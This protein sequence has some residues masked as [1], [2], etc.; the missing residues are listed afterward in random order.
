MSLQAWI[1]CRVVAPATPSA[2]QDASLQAP[3]RLTTLPVQGTLCFMFHD[4]LS[5][6]TRLAH[7]LF[8]AGNQNGDV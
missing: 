3:C 2:S 1:V 4:S 6:A 8:F 5:Q 7:N